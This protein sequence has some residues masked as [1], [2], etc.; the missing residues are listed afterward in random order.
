M[1]SNGPSFAQSTTIVKHCKAVPDVSAD[2]EDIRIHLLDWTRT[3]SE[4][5]SQIQGDISVNQFISADNDLGMSFTFDDPEKWRTELWDEVCS[6][7]YLSLAEE[8]Y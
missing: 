4:C 1:D 3:P 6:E 5:V 8:H 7:A 2:E